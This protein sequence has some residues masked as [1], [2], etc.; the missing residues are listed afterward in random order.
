MGA[1]YPAIGSINDSLFLKTLD[2]KEITFGIAEIVKMGII[3]DEELFKLIE[4]NGEALVDNKF[5]QP[6]EIALEVMLRS[7]QTMMAELQPNIKEANLQRLV[8]FGHTFSPT[9]EAM[10][11]YTIPHGLAVGID[12]LYCTFTA[13]Q[14]RI[15]KREALKR[16]LDVYNL[17]GLDFKQTVSSAQDLLSALDTI[18]AHRGGTLNLVVPKDIGLAEFIQDVSYA[19]IQQAIAFSNSYRR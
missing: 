10:S 17:I 11:D 15:C 2:K 3:C 4:Q 6:S 18:R 14:R 9:I 1:F 16:L 19:E 7:E 12:M 13:V 5:Q 8:D